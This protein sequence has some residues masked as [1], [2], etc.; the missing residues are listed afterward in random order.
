MTTEFFARAS[1]IGVEELQPPFEAWLGNVLD[2]YAPESSFIVVFK[3]FLHHESVMP[4]IRVFASR[5]VERD[6]MV[7]VFL[8]SS[9]E[10]LSFGLFLPD[11]TDRD[12]L[13]KVLKTKA[14]S[15][16]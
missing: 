16:S 7:E 1:G 3:A 9:G 12:E 11:E 6:V 5:L 2:D 4:R 13:I 14:K 15:F 8:S 10:G